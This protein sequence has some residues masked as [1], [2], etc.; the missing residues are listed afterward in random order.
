MTKRIL[1]VDDESSIREALSKVL[2]AEDYEVVAVENGREATEKFGEE[3]VDLVLLDLG[4]PVKDGWGTLEW[5]A[6]VN[7]LL[8]IIII[9]GRSHQREL[10]EKAGADALMQKPLDVPHLL[11]TI[12]E[13][14]DEPMESRAR[15]ARHRASGFRYAACDDEL[16]REMMLKRLT[17]PYPCSADDYAR[18]H[19]HDPDQRTETGREDRLRH[20][21]AG[22]NLRTYENE[23]S[24][25]G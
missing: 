9:T 7:P 5:L 13:L 22:L 10:A 14:T 17:T 15:R 11:R 20:A 3:K 21:V 1:V 23:N 6:K 2:H 16:F 8:P 18:T 12:R 4:L 24:R 25:G 19:G